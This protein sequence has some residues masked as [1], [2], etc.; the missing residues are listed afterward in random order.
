MMRT[1]VPIGEPP[2]AAHETEHRFGPQLRVCD[3]HEYQVPSGRKQFVNML[4]RRAQIAYRMQHIGRDN[5]I[6]RASLESL[7]STRPL[8]VKNF[9][10]YRWKLGELLRGGGKKCGRDIAKDVRM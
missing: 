6:E 5:E 7:L 4:K 1:Q 3:V 2:P 8:K 9:V 10:F